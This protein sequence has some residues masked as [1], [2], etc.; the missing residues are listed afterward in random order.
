MDGTPPA[1]TFTPV[2]ENNVL[3]VYINGTDNSGRQIYYR[4]NLISGPEDEWRAL[5]ASIHSG[6]PGVLGGTLGHPVVFVY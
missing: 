5:G 3:R 1:Y 4:L 6:E 2:L